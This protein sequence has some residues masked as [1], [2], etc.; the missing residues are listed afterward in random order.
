MSRIGKLPVPITSG[1]SVN[2]ASGMLT[3]K[4]PKGEL[5]K[6]LP[7]HVSINI[8]GDEALVERANESGTARAMHGLTRSLLANMVTGVTEG[9]SK[10]LLING[11]GY[12]VQQKKEYLIFTLGYSHLIHYEV[13]QGLEVKV[14]SPTAF[15]IS[16][17]DKELVGKAAAEVRGFRPPEPYKGKGVKYK[18]EIILRKEG[19][20]GA[21]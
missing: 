5:S 14:E 8:T 19:K 18:D 3:V 1:V 4:G 13:P 11:V 12:R 17:I 7:P 6:K 2:V 9:Y 21:R 15:T 10:Q 16:G 20:A